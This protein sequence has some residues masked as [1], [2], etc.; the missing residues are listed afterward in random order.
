M[1]NGKIPLLIWSDAVS[2]PS[3]LARICRDVAYRLQTYL[4][5]TF[6]LATIGYG[7]ASST[8]YPWHQ[9]AWAHNEAW[10]I[11]ELPEVWYDHAGN[12]QSGIIMTI[13]DPSRVI[14]FARP[15]ACENATVQKFLKRTKLQKWGYFPIDATGPN[16]KLSCTLGACLYGY[17]RLLCYSEWAEKIVLNTVGISAAEDAGLHS[18]PHGIETDKF[19]P[20]GRDKN[21]QVFGMLSIGQK[22]SIEPDELLVGIVATN[23]PRKDF[24]LAMQ[25]CAELAKNRRVRMWIH[26]D[27][28]DRYW[29]LPYLFNDFGLH[30]QNIVSLGL[31]DDDTMAKLYSACDVTLGI[32]NAEGFGYPIF[33]SLACGTPCIHGDYGGAAEHLAPEFKVKPEIFRVEGNFNCYRA[34]YD[35]L[36]WVEKILGVLSM[37]APKL[38]EHLDWKNL[39]PRWEAWFRKGIQ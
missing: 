15:E 22:I 32:G 38:P 12:H 23:Q 1:N 7:G 21:R 13:Q 9:Y 3:G 6:H 8:R 16:N 34:I 25:I 35:P 4:G 5:E 2:A 28:V 10:I 19:Y 17:D 30:G 11:R 20:R 29:N 27:S 26:T 31:I 24:G 18:L 37:P 39:W 33:E 36:Q 14:W